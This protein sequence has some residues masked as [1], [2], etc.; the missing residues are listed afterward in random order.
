MDP[1]QNTPPVA[2][3][4]VAQAPIP[5]HSSLNIIML[6]LIAIGGVALVL[7]GAFFWMTYTN[8]KTAENL[9]YITD[10]VDQAAFIAEIEIPSPNPVAAVV[11]AINPIEEAN[12]FASTYVNPFE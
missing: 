1:Q 6:V 8:G 4:P 7:G 9:V 10:A 2:P 3:A 5:H 12:P 11:P